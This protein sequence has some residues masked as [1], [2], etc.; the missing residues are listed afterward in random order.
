MKNYKCDLCGMEIE[1]AQDFTP[2]CPNC[3]NSEYV[4]RMAENMPQNRYS[5]TQTENNLRSA[6]AAESQAWGKYEFYAAQAKTDGYEQIADVFNIT[7][8]NEKAHANMWFREMNGTGNTNAN[9]LSA[10]DGENYEWTDMYANF[11][12]TADREGFHD[13]AQKFRGVADIEHRHEDR[14]RSLISDIEA[15]RIFERETEQKWECRN[16]GHIVIGTH[17]PAECPVCYH[18]QSFFEINAANF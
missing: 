6:F 17:A 4:I 11:A 14:F 8:S 16:C 7:A 12:E 9:L 1:T 18:P 15:S 3:Q 2:V 13:L 5:G 10:A